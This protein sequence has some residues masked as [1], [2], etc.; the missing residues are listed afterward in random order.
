MSKFNSFDSVIEQIVKA[1]ENAG[2]AISDHVPD[3]AKALL[4][5]GAALGVMKTGGKVATGFARKNPALMV[6]T[7]AGAGLAYYLVRRHQKKAQERDRIIE[8]Q[9]SRVR[10]RRLAQSSEYDVEH[11]GFDDVPARRRRHHRQGPRRTASED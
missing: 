8:G 2:G 10:S 9:A 3:R 1:A 5:S 4:T 11:D 6:A 7:V